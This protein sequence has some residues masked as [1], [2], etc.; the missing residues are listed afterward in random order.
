[1]KH[2][3]ECA[4]ECI[5]EDAVEIIWEYAVECTWEDT[6]ES[7]LEDVVEF[8]WEYAV[9]GNPVF[10]PPSLAGGAGSGDAGRSETD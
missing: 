7:T 1:L 10:S 8:T 4:W 3:V 9:V 6:V 2:P 5:W